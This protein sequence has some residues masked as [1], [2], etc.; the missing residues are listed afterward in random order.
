SV[1][2]RWDETNHRGTG[3]RAFISLFDP[4]ADLPAVWRI[5]PTGALPFLFQSVHFDREEACTF[6]VLCGGTRIEIEG[7]LRVQQIKEPLRRLP[8]IRLRTEMHAIH[9]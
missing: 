9:R 1:C 5:H 3:Q 7:E 2:P 6:L 4:T 8:Q